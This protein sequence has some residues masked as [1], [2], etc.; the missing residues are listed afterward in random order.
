MTSSKEFVPYF[1]N[2]DKNLYNKF[3]FLKNYCIYSFQNCVRT[4]LEFSKIQQILFELNTSSINDKY[5][6]NVDIDT[7]VRNGHAV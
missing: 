4:V 2:H 1:Y 3:V 6:T 7:C 5:Y